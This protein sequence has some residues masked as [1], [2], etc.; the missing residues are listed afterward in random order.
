MP[1]QWPWSLSLRAALALIALPSAASAAFVTVY[2]GPTFDG[3]TFTGFKDPVMPFL[4]GSTAGNS[5]AVAYADGGQNI[6][7][8]AFRWDASGTPATQL[9]NLGNLSGFTNTLVWS[10][11]SA[12]T[13][14]GRSD[15]VVGATN[16]GVRPVRWDALGAVTELGN[17]GTDASGFTQ[18]T[19]FVI[20]DAGVAVGYAQKYLA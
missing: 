20:N 10:V 4:P 11:N 14:V 18:S 12:G 9:A 8:R 6:G 5:V 19:A 1:K 3:P 2:G 17:L 15:K 7:E 13:A 16:F